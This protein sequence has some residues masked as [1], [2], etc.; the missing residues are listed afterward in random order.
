MGFARQEYWS[1]S[2]L[3][4]PNKKV[5]PYIIRKILRKKTKLEK[6]TLEN[7]SRLISLINEMQ[8]S[9]TK[10]TTVDRLKNED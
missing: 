5:L 2:P 9:D 4:S 3:P 1:G 6:Y 7:I 10:Y 8:N